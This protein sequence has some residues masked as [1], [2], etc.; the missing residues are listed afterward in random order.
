MDTDVSLGVNQGTIFGIVEIP[1]FTPTDSN[2]DCVKSRYRPKWIFD[3]EIR[4]L[5]LSPKPLGGEMSPIH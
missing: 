5:T 1:P 4:T 2:A 3:P